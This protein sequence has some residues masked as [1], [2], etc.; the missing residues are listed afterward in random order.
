MPSSERLGVSDAAPAELHQVRSD[1]AAQ[2]SD[3][4]LLVAIELDDDQPWPPQLPQAVRD[5]GVLDSRESRT[6]LLDQLTRFPPA[7]LVIAC[8]PRRSP[9]R[10]SLALIAELARCAGST[11]VWLLPAPPGQMLE[12]ARVGDWHSALL[13]LDLPADEHAPLNWLET[14]ND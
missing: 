12:A 8:D 4:A 7:R 6:R 1:G 2:D 13:Q 14:G 9:D 3:G 5:A 11:R 10:G